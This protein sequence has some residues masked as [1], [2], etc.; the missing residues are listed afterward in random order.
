MERKLH[1]TFDYELFF[2]SYTGSIEKCLLEPTERLMT[3][4][5]KKNVRFVFFVDAG[6]LASLY[7]H[8]SLEAC[9][10]DFLSVSAQVKRLQEAGHEIALHVHPHWEDCFHNGKEW[11]MDTTRYKLS[12]FTKKEVDELMAPGEEGYFGVLPGH[13]TFI[14]TLKIGELWDRQGKKEK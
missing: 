5:E 9:R 12:D 13:T 2:G 10:K 1:I 4:A 14:S 3:L 7:K 8:S 11:I 6:Y